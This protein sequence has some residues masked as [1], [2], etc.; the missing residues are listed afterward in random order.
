MHLNDLPTDILE[1]IFYLH[2]Y[3]YRQS[4][5]P[6]LQTCRRWHTVA[7]NHGLLWRSIS[8]W[9]RQTISPVN[10]ECQTLIGLAQ[11][12]NRIGITAT[13]DFGLG[14]P[15]RDP[16]P[17]EIQLFISSVDKNWLSRC[18]SFALWAPDEPWRTPDSNS[19]GDLLQQYSYDSLEK[20]D[21]E[22]TGTQMWAHMLEMLMS[23]VETT[24]PNLRSL[25]INCGAAITEV[26]D[27][28]FRRSSVL[29]R[30]QN[31]DVRH[32]TQPI[33]WTNFENLQ[34]LK[35][36]GPNQSNLPDLTNFTAPGLTHLTLE[37][38]CQPHDIPSNILSQLTH[39]TLEWFGVDDPSDRPLSLPSLISLTFL[40]T[41]AEAAY[42]YAPK[43]DEFIFQIDP[44]DERPYVYPLFD[45]ATISPRVIYLDILSNEDG[46]QFSKPLPVWRRVEELHLMGF[47]SYPITGTC[48][49]RVLSGEYSE[50]AFPALRRL[51]ILHPSDCK[52]GGPSPSEKKEKMDEARGI[53]EARVALGLKPFE[54][55]EV[56]WYWTNGNDSVLEDQS[57]EWWATM[58][59]DCLQKVVD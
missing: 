40:A 18:R 45:D 37:G 39:L 17:E 41:V 7:S 44:Y 42:F 46:E 25:K 36:S 3:L 59:E 16:T 1:K 27:S 22:H 48:L 58:W 28:V 2:V 13:F 47:N 5:K 56:G 31:L 9:G 15:N 35:F 8:L 38:F 12:I 53:M 11:V 51:T 26:A 57:R 55:L 24:S 20:L 19:L 52:D 6:L 32:I 29:R 4:R 10:I 50:H 14:C 49:P 23:R 43:L 33:S 34:Q 30:I 21:L 54:R